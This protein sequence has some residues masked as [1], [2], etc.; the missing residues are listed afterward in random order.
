RTPSISL[1]LA[2]AR[3]RSASVATVPDR[4]TTPWLVSTLISSALR[5]E[6]A[7]K[8]D[9]T[10]LVI[11]VSDTAC[12]ALSTVS[13]AASMVGSAAKA[14]EARDMLST[15]AVRVVA[16]KRLLG[17]FM[18]LLLYIPDNLQPTPGCR[19]TSTIASAVPVF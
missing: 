16:A 4:E 13:L 3:S 15:A 18:V 1:V 8:V 11:Q 17:C 10:L 5:F 6:S 2:I 19:F 9:F 12:S 7:T 14:A